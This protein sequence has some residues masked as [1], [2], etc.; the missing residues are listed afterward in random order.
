MLINK[1]KG[2]TK[3]ETLTFKNTANMGDVIRG[4]DFPP[5]YKNEEDYQN[6]TNAEVC[7]IEGVVIKKGMIDNT[8]FGDFEGYT[9]QVTK[10]IRSNEDVTGKTARK[11]TEIMFVPFETAEDEMNKK[12][13][14]E[15]GLSRVIKID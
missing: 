8:S 7:Y 4:Y 11:G 2:E 10:Q 13:F 15:A 6:K 12:R 1:Q 5:R 9:I 14:V 3:M